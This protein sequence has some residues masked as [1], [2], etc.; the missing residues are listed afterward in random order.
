MVSASSDFMCP[1]S[2]SNRR[3]TLVEGARTHLNS[4]WPSAPPKFECARTLYQKAATLLDRGHRNAE[5]EA[6]MAKAYGTRLANDLVRE[7]M[8]I[9]GALGFARQVAETG[10]S[11][12]LEEMY[13]DAKI[14][15]IFEGA[16][17]LQQW[18]IA[19][20]LIGRDVTG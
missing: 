9:H 8:Q 11:V 5:P 7:A 18:I 19:R 14:L 6:A 16:N 20:Q 4:P 3:Y 15:E 1:V 10:E 12:R 17:E 13:R 2:N